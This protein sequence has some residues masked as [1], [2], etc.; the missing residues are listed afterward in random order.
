MKTRHTIPPRRFIVLMPT[1]GTVTAETLVA[2]VSNTED[3]DIVN[4]DPGL[5]RR[6]A[7]RALLPTQLRRPWTIGKL[8][9]RSSAKTTG[10]AD[11]RSWLRTS[12]DRFDRSIQKGSP[13]E[14]GPL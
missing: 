13:P 7:K 10:A 11:G 4:G 3:H 5:P 6:W 8:G 9:F 1:R 14:R 12:R 2:F